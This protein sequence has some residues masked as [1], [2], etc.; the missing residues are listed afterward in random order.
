M[1]G[2]EL[3]SMPSAAADGLKKYVIFGAG[4]AG[5]YTAWRL[6]TS[7]KLNSNDAL[8][9]NE[10]ADYSFPGQTNSGRKP[11]GRICTYHYRGNNNNAYIE[12]GGMRYIGWNKDTQLGHELVT[13]TVATLDL[14]PVPFKTT[15]NPLFY[16]RGQHVY[17]ND[18]SEANPVRYH[19]NADEKNFPVSQ[20]F[21]QISKNLIGD[22]NLSTQE[23]Q[24]AFYSNG[25]LPNSNSVFEKGDLVSNTGYWNQMYAEKG[26]E[27]Y[28]YAKYA[29]GYASN[30]INWNAADAAIYNGEFAPGGTFLTL[31]E[32]YSTLFEKLFTEIESE[33]TRRG[34][35]FS[36]FPKTRLHS[37]Q[38]KADGGTLYKI[39]SS[40]APYTP[41][42]DVQ[43]VA[44]HAFLAMPPESVELVAQA[45]RYSSIANGYDFLN[46][47][48]VQ[49]SL[50]S[51]IK[52]PA[53]KVAMFFDHDW[54]S[55]SCHPPKVNS[56]D[57]VYGPSVTDLPLRQIYYFGNNGSKDSQE[58]VYGLL[59]SYND[60]EF[61]NFWK[62]LE[63]PVT[64]RQAIPENSDLKV[65]GGPRHASPRMIKMLRAQLAE[66]HFGSV[67]QIDQVPMP[68]EAV[69][70]DWGDNPFG[71]GYHAWAPHYDVCDVIDKIRNL[72]ALAG[73]PNSQVFLVGSAFSN[74]Q[75][76]VEGAFQTAESVLVENFG[77][78]PLGDDLLSK[79]DLITPAVQPV[80]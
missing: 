19:T 22:Q 8:I 42:S 17:Q 27:A 71:A 78:S 32:G 35:K 49:N 14:K 40:N 50:S 75:A 37:I 5:L 44:D 68:K 65:L 61:V 45:T 31:S 46:S 4:P 43:Y 58:S 6:L 13:K 28:L 80:S 60:E 76:W 33:A 9:L 52:Q 70:M 29:G 10:W 62:E 77:L 18:I 39:A 59:A 55:S 74:Q 30:T 73:H 11:A 57:S 12:L 64:D 21:S 56:E 24:C 36:F 41:I 53:Y 54:W 25:S 48:V 2:D 16:L 72:G 66:L 26:N 38:L 3:S 51:V 15:D 20:L 79:S 63:L 1:Q 69:L 23:A 7:G 47:T 67:D 34:I